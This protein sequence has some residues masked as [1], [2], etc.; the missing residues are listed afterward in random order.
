VWGPTP[1]W[2]SKTLNHNPMMDEKARVWFTSRIRP[3]ANPDFCKTGS[4]HPSAKAFPLNGEANRHLS[5]Y[6]PAADKWVLI[7]TCF[8]THHLN[9]A[10]DADHTLWTSPGVVGPGVIGWL[11]R[12]MYEQTGDEVKSQG[13]TPLIVDTN[14]NGKRDE[15]VDADKPLEAG[16]DKRVHLN[17]YA[18]AVAPSDGSLWGTAIGY[19]GQVVRVVP[20]NDPVTTALAEVYEPPLPGFG[21]RGGDIDL[22]GVYWVALS[23]GH[24]GSFDRKKCAVLNGPTALGKH[25]PEGWTLHQLPGPQ[26]RDIKD[27]GSAEASYYVW[28]D[29]HG[30]LGLGKDVPIAMGNLS[31]SLLAFVKGKF[32]T[33]RLPYPSGLFPKNV[34]GRIDDPDTGWKGRAIWTTSGTRTLFHT[35]AGKDSPHKAIK[36]QMRPDPLAK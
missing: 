36:V 8:P 35:E 31:D 9:F 23:S 18:I 20:G 1:I 15:W 12:R 2:D 29:H 33:L 32:V 5:M 6:D 24:L 10:Y 3:N 7:S 22:K 19:P 17:L 4:E 14:G 30:I 26:M 34:D 27:P 25:C 28:V 16:K 21:P 11:N 13:W